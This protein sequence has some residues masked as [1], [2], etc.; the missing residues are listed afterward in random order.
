MR[1][2]DTSP[3]SPGR[4]PHQYVP[5][6][7]YRPVPADIHNAPVSLPVI[8]TIGT[9]L[10]SLL[11]AVIVPSA[12]YWAFGFPAAIISV[13]GAD[14]VFVIGTLFITRVC[15]KHE[16]SV[17]GALFQTITQLGTAFGLAIS[18]VV[19][20][21]TLKSRSKDL[22]IVLNADQ[23][24]APKPAQLTAYKDAMWTGFAFGLFGAFH[25][26]RLF[27]VSGRYCEG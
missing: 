12:P 20:N 25:S 6:Y 9:G 4:P 10:A 2:P 15:L 3:D 1:G 17:G 23:M 22:G 11:F 7:T 26:R 24:N 18:T 14:F 13:A 5:I 27:C 21:A 19:F 8:G 16:L